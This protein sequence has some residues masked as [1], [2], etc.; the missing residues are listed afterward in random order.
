MVEDIVFR[1]HVPLDLVDFVG[2]VWSVF[3]HHDSPF[4]F[5]VDKILVIAL[6]AVLD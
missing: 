2:P 6:E 4:K 1:V 5:T 3:G